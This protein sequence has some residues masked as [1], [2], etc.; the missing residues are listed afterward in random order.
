[1]DILPSGSLIRSEQGRSTTEFD[2]DDTAGDNPCQ[3]Y[4][5]L[6]GNCCEAF[7]THPGRALVKA[8]HVQEGLCQ[9]QGYTYPKAMQVKANIYTSTESSLTP[10]GNPYKM[11][12]ECSPH[13]IIRM[14]FCE[15]FCPKPASEYMHFAK[16][17]QNVQKGR[18]ADNGYEKFVGSKRF[19]SWSKHS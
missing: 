19:D 4:M 6:E 15:E 17:C 11:G 14:G 13:F 12:A 10:H 7:C 1:M 9:D 18:C 3:W 8:S 5:I 2:P 16:T